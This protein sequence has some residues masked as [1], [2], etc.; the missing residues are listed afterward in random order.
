MYLVLVHSVVTALSGGR[1][2]WQ[3]L[4]RTGEVA[5]QPTAG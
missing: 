1:L 2:K 4:R 5:A 3:K